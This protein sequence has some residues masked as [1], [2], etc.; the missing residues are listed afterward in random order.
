MNTEKFS[1]ISEQYTPECII[2]KKLYI[3]SH[4]HAVYLHLL[5]RHMT[6]KEIQ[7]CTGPDPANTKCTQPKDVGVAIIHS[8][9]LI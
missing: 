1:A 7:F 3:I 4:V 8:A 6:E 2:Y 9:G 5:S